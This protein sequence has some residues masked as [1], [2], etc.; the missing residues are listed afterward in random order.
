MD[1]FDPDKNKIYFGSTDK[2]SDWISEI[3]DQGKIIEKVKL[4]LKNYLE[5]DNVSFLFGSGSSIHLGAV[6]IR[7]FPIE[8]EAY[9][10]EKDKSVAGIKTE[11]EKAIKGGDSDERDHSIRRKLSARTTLAGY[12]LRFDIACPTDGSRPLWYLSL[13]SNF[14]N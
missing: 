11:L 14:S 4:M 3:S 8:V 7:N 2:L 1:F 5:L 12:P 6:A 13:G 10:T 9:I